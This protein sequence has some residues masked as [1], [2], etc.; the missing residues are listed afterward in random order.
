[1][2]SDTP[3]VTPPTATLPA[4]A[5]T[6]AREVP[7]IGFVER[8]TSWDW[9]LGAFAILVII[10][11]VFTTDNFTNS[12]NLESSLTRMAAKALM[13]L[14]LA[15]LII[16]REIDISVASIGGLSGISFGMS[17][18]AGAPFPLAIVVALLTGAACGSLNGVLVTKLKLP[19]LIVTLG[20]LAMFR[21]LC[22]VL[23]GGSPVSGMPEPL[24]D[25]VNGSVPGTFIPYAI[26]PFLLL[27]P[28]AGMILHRTVFGRRVYAIGGNPD[29][30]RY[31]G[32][33]TE[34]VLFRLFVASGL[35]A[36]IA[37]IIQ[38]GITSS[39]SP[40]GLFGFELDVVTVCFLGGISFLGGRGRLTGVA[41]ALVV[42]IVLRSILQLRNVAAFGQAAVVGVVLIVSLLLVNVAA[43]VGAARATK[44]TVAERSFDN[45]RPHDIG[46]DVASTATPTHNQRSTS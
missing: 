11:A 22:Y 14:P 40:D 37:G 3:T 41:W 2:S 6:P 4:D 18:E 42:V 45:T 9:L 34:S 21:G 10:V 17:V 8:A 19:S 28:I 13:V 44:R 25:F 43:K 26:V 36:A 29:T 23:V 46:P 39:A 15:M 1:M 30:A 16:A 31:S 33:R 38:T 24:T 12:F 5:E 35:A 7:R 32:V 27:L 20:T